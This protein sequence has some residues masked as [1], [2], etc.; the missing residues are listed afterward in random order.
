MLNIKDKIKDFLKKEILLIIA[1]S[2][3]VIT[4]FFVPFDRSYL[5]YIDW[6][7]I[8]SLF[9]M[10]A[11]IAAFKNIRVFRIT[12]SYFLKKFNSTRKLV[13]AL[14]FITFFFSMFIANDMALLTFLPFTLS[15]FRQYKNVKLCM[16]TI[17]MQN[18][19]ANL[20][21]MLTPFGNPQNLFL[22][23][24]YHIPTADFFSIM[25][26]PFFISVLLIIGVCFFV[27]NKEIDVEVET[28][29][30]PKINRVIFYTV[31]FLVAVLI[32]LRVFPYYT[33]L[34]IVVLSLIILDVRAFKGV[35]YSL[36]LTFFSFFIFSGNLSRI[37][38]VA[39]FL[40]NFISGNVLITGIISCQFISNV[41]TAVL[42][43]H[44]TPHELYPKLLLAVNI[45]GLGTLIASLASLISFK[46][47]S[48]EYKGYAL[49]YLG[50]FS[51]LNFTFLI[52]VL[53]LSVIIVF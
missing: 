25:S 46:A 31:L 30:K 33:G 15:I 14:V 17:V 29:E 22:Y 45:G 39:N 18:I 8:F 53:I 9:A 19:A 47:F 4:S 52:I 3:A 49:K 41:P 6:K 38:E 1:V 20:G 5:S 13:F 36:L 32:V 12:A 50:I 34:G 43:S 42:M 48:K 40:S 24:Y 23:S 28:F 21:G 26:I 27:K 51:L 35:D 44:L 37:P 10:M 2:G 11:V 7:T 16:F